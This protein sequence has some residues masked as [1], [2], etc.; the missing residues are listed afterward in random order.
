MV[1]W[2]YSTTSLKVELKVE[3]TDG[4]LDNLLMLYRRRVELTDVTPTY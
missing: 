1:Y 4:V 2:S 3:L